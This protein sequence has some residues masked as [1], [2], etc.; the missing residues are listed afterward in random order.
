MARTLTTIGWGTPEH[1]MSMQGL[2][3]GSTG[4]WERNAAERR[5]GVLHA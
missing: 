3:T 1:W 4:S 2:A 5:G